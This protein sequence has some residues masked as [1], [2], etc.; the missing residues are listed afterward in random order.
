MTFLA[1]LGE[2]TCILN[3]IKTIQD[4]PLF[5]ITLPGSILRSSGGVIWFFFLPHVCWVTNDSLNQCTCS[6][7]TVHSLYYISVNI[8]IET[9]TGSSSYCWSVQYV[10][11]LRC[12]FNTITR[13]LTKY[14]VH[15]IGVVLF[16]Y[17][18]TGKSL[19]IC[20]EYCLS[21]VSFQHNSW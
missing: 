1:V 14:T 20:T 3:E 2:I 10:I 17:K 7:R 13:R 19:P 12:Y 11:I 18:Y 15:Y 8:S 4:R 9:N 6:T 5:F 16:Q 21:V